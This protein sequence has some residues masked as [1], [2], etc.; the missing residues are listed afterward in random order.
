MSRATFY[1]LEIFAP[2]YNV[3]AKN[4]KVTLLNKFDN[5]QNPTSR[6]EILCAKDNFLPFMNR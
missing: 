3:A 4:S 5:T 6:K 2:N 1:L